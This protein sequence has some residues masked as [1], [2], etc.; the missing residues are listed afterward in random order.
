MI[1]LSGG[2]DSTSLLALSAEEE[3]TSE[4]LFVD[5]GH[6]AAASERA[7]ASAVA[8]AYGVDLKTACVDIGT[9]RAGEVP[10]RNALFI[11]LALA[12]AGPRSTTLFLG[13]HAGTPY[14]D[15]SPA[16]VDAMQ[17]SLDCHRNGSVQLVTPF[18]TWSKADVYAYSR[19]ASVPLELTYSCEI[20]SRPPCGACPSCRDRKMLDAGT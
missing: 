14:R 10:G 7:A 15:C 5:Y 4:A 12:M 6:P 3:G 17:T 18:L 13:V 11:H 2:V 1:L 19:A 8:E 16:F 9:V 20:G